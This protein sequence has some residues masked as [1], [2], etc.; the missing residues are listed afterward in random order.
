LRHRMAAARHRRQRQHRTMDPRLRRH[1]AE[2][3]VEGETNYISDDEVQDWVDGLS[4]DAV[5]FL[6]TLRAAEAIGATV[7]FNKMEGININYDGAASGAIPFMYVAI[8]DV[9]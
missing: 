7:E 9:T 3:Y 1:F 6:E 5:A 8:A 4:T 2:D